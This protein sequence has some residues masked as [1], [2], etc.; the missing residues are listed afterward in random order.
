ME[1]F[2]LLVYASIGII[3]LCMIFKPRIKDNGLNLKSFKVRKNR[4][5]H[6]NKCREIVETYYSKPFPCVRPKFLKGSSGKCLELDM[7]NEEL[8]LAFEYDGIQ[9]SKYSP[10]FHK[11]YSD[12]L[13]QQEN[14]KLKDK[15]CKDNGIT[16]IR[17]PHTVKFDKLQDYILKVLPKKIFKD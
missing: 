13:K 6:E 17:I 4:K 8:K 14:D 2:E 7:Y 3:V 11:N 12:F 5:L 15:L 9:H 10:Y 1:I 16:L